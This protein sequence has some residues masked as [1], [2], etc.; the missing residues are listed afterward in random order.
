MFRASRIGEVA[1]LL[2][3]LVVTAAAMLPSNARATDLMVEHFG[4]V[5]PY[6]P[7]YAN[8]R[9]SALAAADRMGARYARL[10]V[11]RT[12]WS[13]AF[14]WN[15][16]FNG[17]TSVDEFVSD[18]TSHEMRP[19][20]TLSGVRAGGTNEAP[21]S[22]SA[23]GRWCGEA[24]V[25]YRGQ[26]ADFSVWNEPNLSGGD[27]LSPTDYRAY[28]VACRNAIKSTNAAANVFFGEL[29]TGSGANG[30]S[31]AYFNAV[32]DNSAAPIQT[33]GLALHPY[34]F[35]SA[36]EIADATPCKGIGNLPAWRLALDFAVSQGRVVSPGR[37]RPMLLVSEFGYCTG[38]PV[39]PP[40]GTSWSAD[41]SGLAACGQQSFAGV[42]NA[43]MSDGPADAD[44]TR[45]NWIRRAFRWASGGP[46][47]VDVFD[48]HGIA[49]RNPYD[50]TGNE[51]CPTTPR[52]PRTVDGALYCSRPDAPLTY[53]ADPRKGY[54]WNS[55][56][57]EFFAPY[58]FLPPVEALHDV[59][60]AQEPG[61]TV[62]A[63]S[64]IAP[65]LATVN[66]RVNPNGWKTTYRFEYGTT[67]AYGSFAPAPDGSAG[68]GST[69]VDVSATL[70]GLLPSTTYHYRLVA[71]NRVG[72]TVSADRTFTTL[73]V[74]SP[75]VVRDPVSGDQ[76]IYYVGSNGMIC[77]VAMDH[78]GGRWYDGCSSGVQPAMAGTSPSALLEASTRD[79][80]IYY[81]GSNGMICN[82]AMDHAGGRWYD[83][84]SSG[85]QPAMAG[86]SPSALLDE[87]S[88]DQVVYYTGANGRVCNVAMDHA[89]GSWN[90]S[91]VSSSESVLTGTSPA[92]I[93]DAMSRDQWAYHVGGNA[94]VCN[95][96]LNAATATWYNG[97]S[98][99]VE[100]AY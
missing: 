28:Y 86:T 5:Q 64:G 56:L 53:Y 24:A 6:D 81:V 85:V 92:A 63:A 39:A 74:G 66:A 93:Q 77:N 76:W 58:T 41:F 7:A 55:G 43:G 61:L 27:Y 80:T 54:L 83:G 89:A 15:A 29:E 57:V 51:R 90:D 33:D 8:V 71:T 60:G 59:S 14:D 38:R 25:K 21:P 65:T 91:C 87:G 47:Y 79:Q 37:A 19:Y 75:S 11:Y 18:A 1:C 16:R 44:G 72:T 95:V 10:I 9:P 12:N 34:Q 40:P 22:A 50:F 88:R 32:A 78:A 4:P 30:G 2:A 48:Y 35:T 82:V 99:G 52:N 13:S 73:R 26:V 36:P 84:C 94:M 45:A 20:L 100:P 96:A 67:T 49:R 97:C 62:E 23:F 69:A 17:E 70:R 31:C 3:L 98:N 42:V 68:N 46:N